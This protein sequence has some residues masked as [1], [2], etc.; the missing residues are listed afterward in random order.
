[1]RT[2]TVE[3]GSTPT[4]TNYASL[5]SA[6]DTE[7][8][9]DWTSESTSTVN[10]GGRSFTNVKVFIE[11]NESGGDDTT[12]TDIDQSWTGIDG[13][14]CLLI[15]TRDSAWSSV[16]LQ[17]G[18]GLYRLK[19]DM[20]FYVL[21]LAAGAGLQQGALKICG[22][23]LTQDRTAADAVCFAE[24]N[25]DTSGG[26]VDKNVYDGCVFV[27][28]NTTSGEAVTITNR[29]SEFRNCY[30]TANNDDGFNYTN[31]SYYSDVY[32]CI[33]VN[34]GGAGFN[35][36]TLTDG[37]QEIQNCVAFGNT[38]SDYANSPSFTVASNNA[39]EDTTAPGTSAQTS[40]TSAAFVNSGAEDWSPTTTGVLYE[41]GADLSSK[42]QSV[43]AE[44]V[45]RAS[46]WDIGPLQSAAAG[47][48]YNDVQRMSSSINS[49]GMQDLSGGGTQ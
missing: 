18:S 10:V 41:N 44:G 46:T 12:R 14:G 27:N 2:V 15:A 30:A 26:N 19:G 34:C 43:D 5:Q 11:L 3:V 31:A 49:G 1:M 36:N 7:G 24:E 6:L 20:Q 25:G 29:N 17:P 8:A 21:K 37:F 32:G 16:T 35:C 9:T 13:S 45:S 47:G 28:N 4:A 38:G 23:E 42:I 33:A 48:G 22:I 39:S 40:I